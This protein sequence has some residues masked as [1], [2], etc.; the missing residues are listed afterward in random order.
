M[1]QIYSEIGK[2]KRVLVNRPGN[3]L[4]Q[5]HPFHLQ[6]MLFEDTPFLPDA[7]A[8]HDSF[9]KILK[10]NGVEVLYLRELF[11]QAMRHQD[12]KNDFI[13]EFLD[14]SGIP[15]LSLKEKVKEYYETLTEDEFTDTIFCGIRRDNPF[16]Q[17]GKT[18]GEL[19]YLDDLFIV[20]P[21]PNSYFTRDSSINIADSVIIANMSKPYRKREPLLLKYV[22]KYADPFINEPTQNIMDNSLPYGIEGGDVIILSDKVVCIGCTERTAPGAIEYVAPALFSKGFEKILAFELPRGR[23]AMHLDGMLTMVDVD[24]FIFN[25]FLSGS[26]NV[27]ELTRGASDEIKVKLLT[28][29]W[30]EIISKALGRPLQFIPC[31]NGDLIMGTWEMWNLGSN[32]LTIRPGHVVGYDRSRITLDLLDKAGMCVHTFRGSEL[33]RGR[34][35]AHCMSMPLVRE[36]II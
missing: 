27:F 14:A 3:E 26:V 4:N 17:N 11:T 13:N 20:N 22:H 7:Q 34:G 15:S 25:P 18:L 19:T 31:G 10:E 21:M 32:L 24:K 2:L 35:G 1:I 16:F 6:E 30:S 12:A 29:S 36:T 28:A 5:V 23:E 33:S 8:E 9:T